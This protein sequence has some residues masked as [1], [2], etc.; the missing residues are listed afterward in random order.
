MTVPWE[1]YQYF[2]ECSWSYAPIIL[3]PNLIGNMWEGICSARLLMRTIWKIWGKPAAGEMLAC[4]SALGDILWL[5]QANIRPGRLA[6]GM[7]GARYLL[8]S[9]WN[10][11][12]CGASCF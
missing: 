2:A 5:S 6:A 8:C 11:D 3:V 12:V 7:L 10:V 4:S 1:M 9:L